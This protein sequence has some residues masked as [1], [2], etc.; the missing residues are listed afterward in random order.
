MRASL[1]RFRNLGKDNSAHLRL[2]GRKSVQ[3]TYMRMPAGSS[4]DILVQNS[5]PIDQAAVCLT[6]VSMVIV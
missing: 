1:C 5:S 2:L 4:L 6:G 3:N